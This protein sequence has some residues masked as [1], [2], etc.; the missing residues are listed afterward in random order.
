MMGRPS[1][2]TEAFG[3]LI[4]SGGDERLTVNSAG[5]NKY[6]VNPLQSAG[7]FN[8]GSCT[9][10][11]LTPDGERAARSLLNR[12]AA[13]EVKFGAARQS[14][15]QR[16]IELYDPDGTH[17]MN[18]IFAPSG[19]DLCYLPLLFSSAIRPGTP[20]HNI[21]VCCEELGSGSLL[22]HQGKYFSRQSQIARHLTTGE[23]VS[24]KLEIVYHPFS[25][26]DEAAAILDHSRT[27]KQL[28][29]DHSAHSAVIVNL[30]IGSKSGI[31]NSLSIIEECQEY[32]VVW[33]VDLCQMRSAPALVGHLLDLNCLLFITGSKFYQAPPFCGAI[34]V[35]GRRMR[36]LA[37]AASPDIAGFNRLFSRCDFPDDLDSLR[38]R[39]PAYQNRGLL[40][41][42]EAA[43]AEMELFDHLPS[44]K[45]TAAIETWNR[46]VLDAL[47]RS[48]VLEP[49]RDQEQT[50]RSIVSFRIRHGH[51]FLSHE[52][53]QILH[54]QVAE[55][56]HQTLSRHRKVLIGQPVSYGAGSF[57]RLAIGAHDVRQLVTG[58]TD[59]DD[60][61]A[62][63]RL[64]ENMTSQVVRAR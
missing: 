59:F 56:G 13:R 49:L 54:R 63:I 15:R 45:T 27:I 57:L 22:A 18:V 25:A 17:D 61:L 26:R 42:W 23:A 39:F 53:L 32:D 7:V 21:V 12:L 46:T 62:L 52:E 35:P 41:R 48:R 60:D 38:A 14:Q 8:R 33:T 2:S 10:S 28:I 16:I 5:E 9:C 50:N 58:S 40:L 64:I 36:D 24:Q 1:L 47:D 43:L 4:L 51:R 30:V 11:P 29:Q 34:L 20:V 3:A 55:T 37:E 6:Y 19:S 44:D 31:E